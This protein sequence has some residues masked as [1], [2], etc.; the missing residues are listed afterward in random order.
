VDQGKC[1]FKFRIRNEQAPSVAFNDW[2]AN[3]VFIK[4]YKS[5]P[6]IFEKKQEDETTVKVL[7]FEKNGLPAIETSLVGVSW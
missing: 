2:L 3:D 1:D 7:E 4:L 6:K 5:Q